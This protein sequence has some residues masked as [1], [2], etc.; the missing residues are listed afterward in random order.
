MRANHISEELTFVNQIGQTLSIEERMKLEIA[1]HTLKEKITCDELSF[2]GRIEGT[3]KHYYIAV[4]S[5]LKEVNG[6]P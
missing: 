2:W 4:S 1:L 5:L 6:F 3:H